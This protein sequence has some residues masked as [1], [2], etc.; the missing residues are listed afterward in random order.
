MG[1][2]SAKEWV[3]DIENLIVTV[4]MLGLKKATIPR[5]TWLRLMSKHKEMMSTNSDELE[6]MGCVFTYED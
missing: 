2:Q 1:I 6:F 4:T 3:S 5:E